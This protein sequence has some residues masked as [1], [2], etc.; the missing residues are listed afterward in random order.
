MFLEGGQY[1]LSN[2]LLFPVTIVHTTDYVIEESYVQFL[3]KVQQFG[4]LLR[5][6]RHYA[7]MLVSL[8]S[9][10]QSILNIHIKRWVVFVQF[11]FVL[12]FA[13]FSHY[14]VALAVNNYSTYIANSIL[15]TP[16]SVSVPVPHI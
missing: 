14:N 9:H 8:L 5:E 3:V 13:F 11:L 10:T 6:C 16:V 12:F 2:A 7:G 1:L 4:R 15:L